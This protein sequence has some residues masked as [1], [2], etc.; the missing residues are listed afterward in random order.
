METAS[1]VVCP[2][3][4]QLGMSSLKYR[5]AD[6]VFPWESVD[7]MHQERD[8][9]RSLYEKHELARIAAIA[10]EHELRAAKPKLN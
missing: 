9:W 7:E 3:K 2:L 6:D 10:A 8:R 1:V 4:K 5:M